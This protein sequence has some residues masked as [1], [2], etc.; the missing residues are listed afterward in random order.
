MPRDAI[1]AD[2]YLS[3]LHQFWLDTI[4]PLTAI[5]EGAEA[6]ELTPQDTYSAAQVAL[7]L[8][9]NANNHMAQERRKRILINVSPALKSMADEENP[10]QQAVLM[11]FGEEFAKKATDRVE[12]IK[13]IKKITYQKPGEKHPGRFLGFHP[14]IKQMATG[15]VTKVAV[16]DSSPTRG[17]VQLEQET[18]KD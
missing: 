7:V 6:G 4:A 13:A 2:G 16:E 5:L 17:L 9:G 3:C 1:K 18:T 14:G 10:L 11:L 8:M 12:A 15:V